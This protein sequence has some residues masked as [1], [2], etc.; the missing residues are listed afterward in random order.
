MINAKLQNIIDTKSAIGNAINNKGGSITV[1]TPFY[2]YAPAIENISSGGGAYSTFVAEAQD[3]AKYTVYNGYHAITN[4]T[5]NLSNNFV[6]NQWL[7]NNSATGDVVLSNVVVAQTSNAL[8]IDNTAGVNI[9]LMP[10]V[11]NAAALGAIN[12]LKINNGHI[13]IA[14]SNRSILKF[15]ESN[16]SFVGNSPAFPDD[17]SSMVINNSI[18]YICGGFGHNISS[19]HEGNLAFRSNTTSTPSQVFRSLLVANSNLYASAQNNLIYRF[20]LSTMALSTSSGNIT[21]FLINLADGTPGFYSHMYVGG[22]STA[23]SVKKLNY[24]MGVQANLSNYGGDV[25]ALVTNSTFLYVGGSSNRTIQK[26]SQDNNAFIANSPSTGFDIRSL[27]TN[28]GFVYA[29]GFR[30]IRKYYES[31]LAFVGNTINTSSTVGALATNN[32]YFYAGTEA[33]AGFSQFQE[34]TNNLV[35]VAVFNI[36]QIKE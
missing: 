19:Y 7:L 4:P 33:N 34:Q 1:E 11:N 12:S 28:N 29:G 35:N 6:F 15:N 32:T 21:G 18:I 13:F 30:S 8:F 16:L 26:F 20:T 2:E 17:I 23:Q 27:A 31:N 10:F 24:A 9:A 36:T 5:P 14:G 22:S 3:N 25:N